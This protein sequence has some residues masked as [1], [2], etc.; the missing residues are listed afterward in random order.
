MA[1]SKSYPKGS[2]PFR[3]ADPIALARALAADKI[4]V[5]GTGRREVAKPEAAEEADRT[6]DWDTWRLISDPML[7]QCVALSLNIDPHQVRT[8][9]IGG[10]VE[11]PAFNESREFDRRLYIASENLHGALR[12]TRVFADSHV[13]S[14]VSLRQFAGWVREVAEWRAPAELLAMADEQVAIKADKTHSEKHTD[15]ATTTRV[16]RKAD[17]LGDLGQF[18]DDVYAAANRDDF[19]LGTGNDRKPLPFSKGDLFKLF[20]VRHPGHAVAQATFE[21][22]LKRIKVKVKSGQK[23]LDI[24][25]LTE[26][27]AVKL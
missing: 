25:Q 13:K 7:W 11:H 1:G 26:M 18:I 27:M 5:R 3:N 8:H 17:R 14:R 19:A 24:K 21:D 4:N 12:C 6:P 16:A 10:T 20:L 22:D 23:R 2:T 15:P 9:R